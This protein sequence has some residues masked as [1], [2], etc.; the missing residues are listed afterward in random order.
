MKS[1]YKFTVIFV[2]A[3]TVTLCATAEAL[4][5]LDWKKYEGN[6]VMVSDPNSWEGNGIV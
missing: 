6:P 4:C 5:Q 3:L 2:F 1:T